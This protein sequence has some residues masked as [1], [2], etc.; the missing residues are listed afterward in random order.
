MAVETI[1]TVSPSTNQIICTR[2]GLSDADIALLL[3]KSTQAFFNYRSTP[4]PERQAIIGR[5]LKLIAEKQN[6]LAEKLTEQMGRPVAYAAKE[7]TTAVARGE[8]L[9]KICEDALEDTQGEPENGYT[10]YIRKSPIGP[11]LILF[12]WNVGILLAARVSN[13]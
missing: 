10:R 5:A 9:L 4:L 11:V 7:I 13:S 8:Y 6:V 2:T 3:A 1:S 12:T